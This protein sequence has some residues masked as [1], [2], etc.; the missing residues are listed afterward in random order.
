MG[1]FAKYAKTP[2]MLP[3]KKFNLIYG[4]NGS[5]KTTLSRFFADLNTGKSEGFESLKYKI[6]TTDGTY[7]NGSPY[8][9]TIRV[10]NS[11][12]VDANIGQLEGKL[13]PIYVIGEEN[14]TL[15]NSVKSDDKKLTD[16]EELHKN[17]TA[18]CK[19]L[20]IKRGKIFTNVAVEILNS[21]LGTTTR[22]YKKNHAEMAFDALDI[23]HKLSVDELALASKMM[24]QQS[25][26]KHD[27]EASFLDVELKSKEGAKTVYFTALNLLEDYTSNI[28]KKSTTSIAISRLA[29]QPEIAKWV[30][31][32]LA[33]HSHSDDQICEYCRQDIPKDRLQELAAHFN[34]SDRQLKEEIERA[35]QDIKALMDVAHNFIFLDS[36]NLY[37]ELQ[38]DYMLLVQEL[39][40]V[41]KTI[42][43]HLKTLSNA[44]NSKLNRR[45]E[46]YSSLFEKYE[47]K[48]WLN[49]LK[50]VNAVVSK[51]NSETDAF[52][53]RLEACFTKIETHYLSGI[54]TVVADID[55]EISA[56][57][58]DIDMCTDGS[59]TNNILGI[60]A[61]R[62]Q[63]A[64]N[65]AK[66]SNSHQAAI[67][68]SK[69]L[70]SF[71][72]RSD[73]RFEPEGD[74][75]RIIRIDRAAKRLS[76]GEK[77][78][79][80]FLY[81]V[82]GLKDQG[83]D[84]AEGIVVIDDPISSLDSSSIYQ[85]FSF[86]KNA[87]KDVN[88]VFLLTH[89]F[90][91][92]KLLLNWFQNIK[93]N[94][95][96]RTYWMLHCECN[97]SD[98][99]ESKIKPL[100]KVLLENKNEFAYLLKLLIQFESDGTID[101]AYHIPNIIRKVLETFL[102]QHSTGASL[103]KKLEQIEFD[104]TKK[105]A[106]QKFANDLSHSTFSGID[107]AL[108]VE[109]QTN[110]KHLLDMIETVAPVHYKALTSIITASNQ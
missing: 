4:L 87:V 108:V 25:M 86:L 103:Y 72:G 11:E 81:F 96:G 82:V 57:V 99:R 104:E 77:T 22:T 50:K 9:K 83:F 78:A 75:Y 35:I 110:I 56:V 42:I 93:P 69:M 92:L 79:I 107:P 31:D 102:E 32:G 24:K 12:Y 70:A 2:E 106:I 43:A 36:A 19:K 26:P 60:E 64:N 37:P 47:A 28:L 49:T 63:I 67:K 20:K 6:T 88:Q 46:S 13:N 100:D 66:I 48:R 94:S 33:I 8:P 1:V 7:T 23:P 55:K 65:R 91:F 51:H 80:T 97:A 29:K 38:A 61:I 10:F 59:P 74:G 45:T 58:A 90:E 30:E 68:L 18:E 73:L 17:K 41:R 5:G 95:T 89:N 85:A 109:T 105:S 71:L 40:D 54:I 14:K 76:E 21:A 16:L 84:A 34:D 44:L 27:D 98:K 52:N 3:F 53:Q 15:A 62:N 101:N 39:K